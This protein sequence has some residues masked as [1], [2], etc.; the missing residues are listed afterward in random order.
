VFCAGFGAVL[1]SADL[2]DDGHADLQ[3]GC[4]WSSFK[5]NSSKADA[6]SINTGSL[7]AYRSD[8]SNV[9]N[10][11]GNAG[12]HGQDTAMA[13]L[14]ARKDAALT[15]EG[16]GY[17]WL[18]QSSAKLPLSLQGLG[19]AAGD[20]AGEDNDGS[21]SSVLAVGAPGHRNASGVTVGAVHIYS[22]TLSAPPAAQA[23][24]RAT[25]A[26]MVAAP[27]QRMCTLVGESA[28]AEFGASVT[29]STASMLLAVGS[30]NEGSETENLR[31]GAVRLFDLNSTFWA[32]QCAAG[33]RLTLTQ[34]QQSTATVGASSVLRARIVGP[35]LSRFGRAVR[36]ISL[37]PAS[38]SSTATAA[39][40]PEGLLVGAP[41]A[42]GTYTLT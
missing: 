26:T 38:T 24:A 30:P 14:D 33:R 35:R 37:P 18:G 9:K 21:G 7:L 2:D 36:F 23:N 17:E 12:G 4:P 6:D 3:V 11:T 16:E 8:P 29:V 22:Y 34:L 39:A 5:S 40:V 32:T 13:A 1:L 20:A 27:P 19:N 31:G 15:L 10:A 42:N 28:L 41:L 25:A